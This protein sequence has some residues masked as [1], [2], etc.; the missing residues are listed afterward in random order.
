M[1]PNLRELIKYKNPAQSFFGQ[2][3]ACT[4]CHTDPHKGQL[5]SDCSKCH[6]VESWKAAKEFDHSK[7]RYPL[8]SLHIRVQCEKCHKPDTPGGPARYKDTKFGTCFDRHNDPHHGEFKKAREVCH[9]TSSWKTMLPGY[10]FDH[11]LAV[12]YFPLTRLT[13]IVRNRGASEETATLA[14]T[15][16]LSYPSIS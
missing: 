8:T 16:N 12:A 11:S 10:D 1:L 14:F 9:T 15:G 13:N 2:S 7:T 5:G 4:P 3:P 6:N